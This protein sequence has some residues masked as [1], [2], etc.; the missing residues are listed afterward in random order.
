MERWNDG[1]MEQRRFLCQPVQTFSRSPIPTFE[2][3]S[4]S[5]RS[6]HLCVDPYPSAPAALAQVPFH[7]PHQPQPTPRCPVHLGGG[8]AGEGGGLGALL[9]LLGDVRG[10]DSAHDTEGGVEEMDDSLLLVVQRELLEHLLHRLREQRDALR[11]L[12]VRAA[13][14]VARQVVPLDSIGGLEAD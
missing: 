12:G 5:L 8:G 14:E 7:Q 1:T 3:P 11:Q 13:V 6:L 10:G 9:R 4:A 2:K